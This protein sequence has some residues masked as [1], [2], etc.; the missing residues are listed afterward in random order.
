[1]SDSAGT[2]SEPPAGED[3]QAFGRGLEG[4][5]RRLSWE[6]R[7][8]D[9]FFPATLFSDPAWDQLLEAYVSGEAGAEAGPE[10]GEAELPEAE[11]KSLL[12]LLALGIFEPAELGG[13]AP[14]RGKYT[15]R[16]RERMSKLLSAIF[17][18]RAHPQGAAGSADEAAAPAGPGGDFNARLTVTIARLLECL[19]ELDALQLHEAGAHLSLAVASLERIASAGR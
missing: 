9:R 18:E 14:L 12:S 10:G 11:R 8:R 2:V 17:L 5:A 16:G 19:D 13:S 1:M 4:F 7:C 15:A 3:E 6:R